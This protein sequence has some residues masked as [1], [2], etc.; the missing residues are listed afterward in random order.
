MGSL[1][2]SDNVSMS[3]INLVFVS[4][5]EILLTNKFLLFIHIFNPPE[6]GIPAIAMPIMSIT[7]KYF[8]IKR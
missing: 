8:H 3:I 7:A 4:N 5:K 1:A 6:L 2:V